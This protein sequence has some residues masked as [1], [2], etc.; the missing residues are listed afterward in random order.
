MMVQFREN[1]FNIVS[2]A[3]V[4]GEPCLSFELR[5]KYNDGF[6]NADIRTAGEDIGSVLSGCR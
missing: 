3:Q 6:F 4:Y 1:Q 5:T 2:D